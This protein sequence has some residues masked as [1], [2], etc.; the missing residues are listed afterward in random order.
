[1]NKKT[2]KSFGKAIIIHAL[3]ICWMV[4]IFC[5][6]AQPGEESGDLSEG[7]TYWL[8]SLFDGIFNLRWDESKLLEITDAI[9]YPIRKA[10]HMTEFGILS[11][12]CYVACCTYERIR[13]G[14]R[15]F[16]VALLFVFFYAI[17]D[18]VHQLFVPN[19]Y[20]CFTDVLVDTT[21]GVIALLILYGI[22]RIIRK[23]KSKINF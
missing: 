11:L 8:V 2:K 16:I 19:R 6:S 3:V 7:V 15:R 20:G 5:F 12:L 22:I 21:G 13:V 17:T 9:D 4:V 18:E 23:I 14:K 1:M 10:A